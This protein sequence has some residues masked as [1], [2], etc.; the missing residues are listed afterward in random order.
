MKLRPFLL[1]SLLL[2]AT[3]L[4]AGG[5]QAYE[6]DTGFTFKKLAA[7]S[8]NEV[9]VVWWNILQGGKL[10]DSI[11][12]TEG[13]HPLQV[14]L[15]SL[16]E[17]SQ[18][19]EFLVLGEYRPSEIKP[20][21]DQMLRSRYRHAT[22]IPYSKTYHY[23]G[24]MIFTDLDTTIF[25][26]PVGFTIPGSSEAE[27]KEYRD[28]WEKIYPNSKV[29]FDRTFIAVRYQWNGET[30]YLLPFHAVQPWIPLKATYP[31]KLSKV[32]TAVE[33]LTGTKNPLIN[34]LAQYFGIMKKICDPEK[35][36]VLMIGD[37]NTPDSLFGLMPI[38]YRFLTLQLND[39]FWRGSAYTFPAPSSVRSEHSPDKKTINHIRIDHAL[40]SNLQKAQEPRRLPLRGS[41]HFPISV[42]LEN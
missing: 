3:A 33:I 21:I 12:K 42:K 23:Q 24:I 17:A 32:F 19:P 37:L 34:Q 4:L 25:T 15:D 30:R 2:I 7:K 28:A 35:N 18:K 16:T 29:S 22:F 1:T 38:G 5:A 31:A 36:K 6:A 41:D 40:V 11:E 20:E 27:K 26:H 10:S 8:A 13:H 9:R 39:T 14:N